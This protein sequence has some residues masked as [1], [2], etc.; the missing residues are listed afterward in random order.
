[1]RVSTLEGASLFAKLRWLV[2]MVV[3]L[4]GMVQLTVSCDPV[5]A[6]LPDGGHVQG[7]DLEGVANASSASFRL[8]GAVKPIPA[9]GS[10]QSFKLIP[11][12]VLQEESEESR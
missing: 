4:I 8:R 12:F 11:T 2:V 1:M 10:S 5:Q 9:I 6:R 7:A 3:L